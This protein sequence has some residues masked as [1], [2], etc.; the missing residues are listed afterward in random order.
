MQKHFI[1]SFDALN[2]PD[3]KIAKILFVLLKEYLLNLSD[4]PNRDF[5]PIW[6]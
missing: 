1:Q 5:V 6:T 4:L 2:L 3:D